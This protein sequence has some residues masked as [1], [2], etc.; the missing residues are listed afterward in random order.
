VYLGNEV[1]VVTQMNLDLSVSMRV[2]Y[3]AS[4]VRY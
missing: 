4:S 1:F 3:G 2:S